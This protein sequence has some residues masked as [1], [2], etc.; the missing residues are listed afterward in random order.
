VDAEDHVK[1]IN[2]GIVSKVGARRLTFTKLSQVIGGSPYASPEELAGLRV[3]ARSDIYSLGVMLYE[4]VTGTLP[5]SAADPSERL[6]NF[7][8]PPRVANPLLAP[9]LQEVIYRALERDPRNRYPSARE[10]ANDLAHLDQVVVSD[11]PELR[12]WN[13]KRKQRFN[14]FLFYAAVALIPIF[15]LALLICVARR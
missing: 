12:G 7:P 5:F 11:R 10:F 14:K 8:V 3:D 9:E 15:V 6:T 13:K 2:F 1:L 4:M